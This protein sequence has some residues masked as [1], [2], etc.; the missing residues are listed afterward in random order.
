[1]I[2]RAV[3]QRL[4]SRRRL[5]LLF[6]AGALVLVSGCTRPAPPP[7][8]TIVDVAVKDFSIRVPSKVAANDVVTLHVTNEGAQTHEFVVGRSDGPADALPIGSDGLRV[9][10]DGVTVEGELEQVDIWTTETLTLPLGPGRYVFFC[11]L[12]GHYLGGMHAEFEVAR[13]G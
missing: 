3:A 6:G 11:N 1:V 7:T 8:G 2:I 9:D 13:D 10:E 4:R 5:A 12:E